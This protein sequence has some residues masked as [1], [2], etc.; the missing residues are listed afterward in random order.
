[1][2]DN[3]DAMA[4]PP[5]VI[6]GHHSLDLMTALLRFPAVPAI[7]FC[8]GWLPWQEAPLHFPRVRRYVVVSQAIRDKLLCQLHH[9][10]QC[11]GI[12]QY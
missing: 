2:I 5:D 6:H 8:H 10:N 3:L 1:M 4:T 9:N 11:N 12:G 7:C